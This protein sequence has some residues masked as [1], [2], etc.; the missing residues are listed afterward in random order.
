MAPGP[1]NKPNQD[2]DGGPLENHADLEAQLDKKYG[3]R[4]AA[5]DKSKGA[6]TEKAKSAEEAGA[7]PGTSAAETDEQ[8][9]ARSKEGGQDEDDEGWFSGGSQSKRTGRLTRKT[10]TTLA[11]VTLLA[12]GTI[13]V[14]T[15]LRGPL[16]V[17]HFAQLLQK[18]H[19]TD[20][21]DFADMRT[22][23]LLRNWKQGTA[24]RTR[25]GRTANR[26]ADLA[27][28]RFQKKTGLASIYDNTTGRFLGYAVVD[29]NKS[30]DF[31][32][33]TEFKSGTD[34]PT[35]Q[36]DE[37]IPGIRGSGR[38]HAHAIINGQRQPL[39]RG[40]DFIDLRDQRNRT[41]RV[42]I[43]TA[44]RGSSTSK[45]AGSISSRLLVRRAGVDFHPLND[46]RKKDTKQSLVDF[47][48]ERKKERADSIRD[49]A[50]PADVG[51]LRGQQGQDAQGNPVGSPD[52]D[53]AANSGNSSLDAGK[54]G[55]L[56]ATTATVKTKLSG[57]GAQSAVGVLCAVKQVGARSQQLKHA[58]IVLP[59]IRTGFMGVSAGNQV[60][61]SR[62]LN[63]DELGSYAT[64]FYDKEAETSWV[65][66]RSIQAE[67]GQKTTGPDIADIAKPSNALE[68]P[69]FFKN[70]DAIPGIN[71]ACGDNI[72]TKILE[73]TDVTGF[74]IGTALGA[75]GV[76]PAEMAIEWI[77]R[78]LSG[79]EVNGNPK[80][81]ELGNNASYGT[82][83]GAIDQA[84]AMGGVKMSR[85]Q[86]ATLDNWHKEDRDWEIAHR[87]F[88]ERTLDI[89]N[90][91]SAAGRIALNIPKE[92]AQAITALANAP[93]RLIAMGFKP[94][95]AQPTS[96]YDYGFDDY[97]FTVEEQTS[98]SFDSPYDN[99]AYIEPLLDG[100]GDRMGY[101]DKY[102]KPCFNMTVNAN[103]SNRI[104]SGEAKPHHLIDENLCN[105]NDSE[106]T[107][108]RFYIA[109]FVAAH[110]LS[111]FEGDTFSC[112]QIG[113]TGP[114]ASSSTPAAGGDYRGSD[115]SA[116]QC[117]VGQDAGLGDT[118]Q[119]G[120]K[121]RLCKVS[122]ITVNV[123]IEKNIHTVIE[124]GRKAGLTFSGS[125]YRSHQSQIQLR[126]AHCG[127]S[128]YAIYEMRSSQCSPPTA[129][130]G[131]SMHE[132][133]LAADFSCSGSLIRSRSSPCFRWLEENQGL[134][135]LKNLPS[136][137]WHW[138]STG[139]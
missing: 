104:E 15:F 53:N 124:E 137:T 40:Y 73:I 65:S 109:D 45:I 92:P 25:L 7:T 54:T 72:V 138:S 35:Y 122:G 49:G 79:N 98:P 18:F 128:Q 125:G 41:K 51:R 74:L 90:V 96:S 9:L 64:D 57:G 76:D 89:Y 111:C 29:R 71:Q 86:S 34:A 131:R 139:G 60:M 100:A 5:L 113:M 110:S 78:S 39:S 31:L 105:R 102:G 121:I 97:G 28:A 75:A 37:D 11:I 133:G 106:L 83:L 8:E 117:T 118:P 67:L 46:V 1:T 55:D 84:I 42:F 19:L 59:L 2:S 82:K 27:E 12:G 30:V 66:A 62:D 21:E 47:Y 50:K 44:T 22:T 32:A 63:M 70:V 119:E 3:D 4:F 80:G 20:N 127:A 81:A 107:K 129:R 88:F 120:V 17:V 132:W 108:Y 14:G 130:P 23:N 26:A 43:R 13:G 135:S 95:S 6:N 87:G 103:G 134:H 69:A 136:E 101:N 24:E 93:A 85:A 61:S 114:S 115:T 38:E 99:A 126:R 77:A 56:G 123:A 48:R 10:K 58:N 68:K 94:V 112:E 16:E 33:E 116:Q 91:D 52:L 36:R